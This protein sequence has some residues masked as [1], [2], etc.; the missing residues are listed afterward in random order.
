MHY[1]AKEDSR[2]KNLVCI[3]SS[4]GII[5]PK[6]SEWAV[7]M[8]VSE[9]NGGTLIC[10]G[11][12][13]AIF[14]GTGRSDFGYYESELLT[15][16]PCTAPAAEVWIAVVPNCTNSHDA[17]C[18][19]GR[20]YASDTNGLNSINGQYGINSNNGLGPTLDSSFFGYSFASWCNDLGV[21]C[22][23]TLSAGVL[24]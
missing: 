18:N 22:G 19:S 23:D 3:L 4:Y 17:Y 9:G 10:S 24:K 5:D 12:N 21:A 6:T 8:G 20:Y 14:N 11:N 15:T 16:T 2:E 1:C 13:P 7:R